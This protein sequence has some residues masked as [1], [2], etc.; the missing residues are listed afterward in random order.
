MN[1]THY[2]LHK[3]SSVALPRGQSLFPLTNKYLFSFLSFIV[4]KI[5]NF[6]TNKEIH[7]INMTQI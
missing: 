3:M 4:A 7:S 5:E 1:I 6:Q 2:I